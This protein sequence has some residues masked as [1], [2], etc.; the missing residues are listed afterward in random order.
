MYISIVLFVCF[1]VVAFVYWYC[2]V[3]V[4]VVAVL[5]FPFGSCSCFWFLAFGFYVLETSHHFFRFFVWI[6]IPI[7]VFVVLIYLKYILLHYFCYMMMMII[8]INYYNYYQSVQTDIPTVLPFLTWV[9]TLGLDSTM[10][11]I[12][13]TGTS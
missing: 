12:I 2:F 8:I 1:V 11:I 3:C 10:I 9:K 5:F 4:V 6:D 7:S 13:T